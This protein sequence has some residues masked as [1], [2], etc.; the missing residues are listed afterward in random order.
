M[1]DTTQQKFNRMKKAGWKTTDIWGTLAG[2]KLNGRTISQVRYLTD[3]EQEQLG[4]YGKSLV[5]ILDDGNGIFASQDDEG[6][7][8]GSLFTSWD[9]LDTI[10]TI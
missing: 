5:I 1:S 8:P 10:P 2:E 9:D 6:N 4:W 3:E 7:G